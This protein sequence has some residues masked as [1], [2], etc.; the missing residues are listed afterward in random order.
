MGGLSYRNNEQTVQ[1]TDP[2]TIVIQ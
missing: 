2:L 1:V